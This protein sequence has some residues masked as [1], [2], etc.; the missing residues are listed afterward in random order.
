M[1][2]L[3]REM[4]HASVC[5]PFA[6]HVSLGAL[7]LCAEM[8]PV[9]IESGTEVSWQSSG[10]FEYQVQYAG[11]DGVFG[12]TAPEFVST[13]NLLGLDP[14]DPKGKDDFNSVN[15]LNV[16]VD[17]PVIV[18]LSSKDVI[19]SFKVPV[20]RLTQDVIPGQEIKIWFESTRIG[21]YDLACAQLCG[22]GHFRMR[23]SLNVQSKADFTTWLEDQQSEAAA[24]ED[25]F[26]F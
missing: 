13:D 12:S 16:E 14:D 20:L 9:S 8:V 15:N 1:T 4:K 7:S 3:T 26:S 11:A 6:I 25:D 17:R 18:H 22:L 19:H 5:I 10:E 21:N 24:E 2:Y 23:G